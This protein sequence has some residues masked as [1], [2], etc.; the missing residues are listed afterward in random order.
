MP[1][2]A[3]PQV[4]VINQPDNPVPVITTEETDVNVVSEPATPR[5]V[6][7]VN[8]ADNPVPVTIID[9]CNVQYEYKVFRTESESHD[10]A[11][12]S[13]QTEPDT[14]ANKGWEVV[15]FSF[16]Q[17]STPEWGIPIYAYIYVGIMR[18]LI[19]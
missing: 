5:D 19:Q 8:D 3:G 1:V 13:F 6:N 17:T 9:A 15:S 18:R 16:G 10:S 2:H 4:E 11:M 12:G 14:Y 7:I